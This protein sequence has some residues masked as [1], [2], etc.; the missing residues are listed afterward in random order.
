M[1]AAHQ[2][3][4]LSDSPIRKVSFVEIHQPRLLQ[5]ELACLEDSDVGKLLPV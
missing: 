5:A 4:L 3:G 2:A 1:V